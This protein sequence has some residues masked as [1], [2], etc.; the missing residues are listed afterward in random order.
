MAPVAEVVIAHNVSDASAK[1]INRALANSGVATYFVP[2]ENSHPSVDALE[3]IVK[4]ANAMVF[5][6]GSFGLSRWQR[7]YLDLGLREGIRIIPALIDTP[8]KE[9]HSEISKIFENKP[10]YDLRNPS[11]D[12]MS[13]FCDDVAGKLKATST[14]NDGDSLS[15]LSLDNTSA[16]CI[17]T[18][19]SGAERDKFDVLA[20]IRTS[21]DGW[22]N[23]FG[24]DLRYTITRRYR[25]IPRTIDEG[26]NAQRKARAAARA[27][28]FSALQICDPHNAESLELAEWSMSET[29]EPNEEVRFRVLSG[30]F[31]ANA[32]NV[33]A[34]LSHASRDSSKLVSILARTIR[35]PNDPKLADEFRTLSS[36]RSNFEAHV[37]YLRA[38]R[39][40]P[41][42]SLAIDAARIFRSMII[43]PRQAAS[44]F[45]ALRH[46]RC[47]VLAAPELTLIPGLESIVDLMLDIALNGYA[48]PEADFIGIL[49]SFDRGEM[50]SLLDQVRKRRPNYK[51]IAEKLLSVLG[52]VFADTSDASFDE[53]LQ[54]AGYRSDTIGRQSDR[55]GI[56]REVHVLTTLMLSK[57]VVPPLAIGLFGKWGAGKSFFMRSME[58]RASEISEK[59]KLNGSTRFCRNIV[60]IRFNAWHYADSSLWASLVTCIFEELNVHFTPRQSLSNLHVA[61]SRNVAEKLEQLQGARALIAGAENELEFDR[62]LKAEL[63]AKR[64][65]GDIPLTALSV[66]DAK[67]LLERNP[68]LK[69]TVDQAFE[70][71]AIPKALSGIKNLDAALG[72]TQSTFRRVIALVFALSRPGLLGPVILCLALIVFGAPI[73]FK[74]LQESTSFGEVLTQMGSKVAQFG[75]VATALAAWIRKAF[76]TLNKGLEKVEKA[77]ADIE[78][79]LKNKTSKQESE[80]EVRIQKLAE[81]LAKYQQSIKP[82]EE[83]LAQAQEKLASVAE[84]ASLKHFL[85]E[86]LRTNDYS[87]H[88]GLLATVRDDFDRLTELIKA[89]NAEQSKELVGVT[90]GQP[91]E[92][93]ILYIDDLDRCAAPKVVEVLQAVHLLL[94][95]PLFIV[96]VGVDVR[97][98][99]HSLSSHYRQLGGIGT[100]ID[101][102]WV[103]KP[104][105]YLEKIFQ[106]SY[107]LKPMSEQSFGNLIEELM[108]GQQSS[109]PSGQR[110]ASHELAPFSQ[111]EQSPDGLGRNGAK[112]ASGIGSEAAVK[113]V[114]GVTLSENQYGEVDDAIASGAKILV[115]PAP[116]YSET[117]RITKEEA[118]S[119]W[120]EEAVMALQPSE[121]R[122][123]RTLHR[124]IP[125]PRAAKRLSNIY[126]I[127]K[128]GLPR[129]LRAEFEGTGAELGQFRV[130]MLLLAIVIFD[131]EDAETVFRTLRSAST[132]PDVRSPLRLLIEKNESTTL[133]V[134][135]EMII[136]TCE[137][138]GL[139][140]ESKLFYEWVP[141][142]SRFSFGMT[143]ADNVK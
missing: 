134:L 39:I 15:H 113:S 41:M 53:T 98:L 95:Y 44:I 80:L 29:N 106:I 94:A 36:L 99:M 74:W 143:L 127:L 32:S 25:S 79:I 75:A 35:S 52:S 21:A 104:Q 9:L 13:R 126:R 103:A 26:P 73:F 102:D 141:T 115:E 57:D 82:I 120:A 116:Q 2:E 63:E 139:S 1:A 34:L 112:D 135:V 69:R 11:Q 122:F 123:A 50:V 46:D 130:P 125:S 55:L 64:E 60:Q 54:A 65:A 85:E 97:W 109:V 4:N 24:K 84:R 72:E 137:R 90:S 96:V 110:L 18:L 100:G 37:P 3:Q 42:P 48:S 45:Y 77:R 114:N 22:R 124:F 40:V 78:H 136:E 10:I 83:E 59:A 108:A 66:A 43:S 28:L 12:E 129:H 128:A 30:A 62:R 138:E 67:E 56:G 38:M 76:G 16:Y 58:S 118:H 5:L 14:E 111:L 105:H 7:I 87:K 71:L 132:A 23:Q 27:W 20:F 89:E 86:R 70:S 142:V 68:E 61:A 119:M 6:I 19:V 51:A 33:D 140:H 8:T 17:D 81:D 101:A 131:S 93:V 121:V 31:E 92:R 107:A 49:R 117:K 133:T 88:R 91:I 47:A